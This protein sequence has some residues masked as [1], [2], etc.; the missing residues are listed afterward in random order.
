MK[1]CVGKC[2][3]VLVIHVCFIFYCCWNKWSQSSDHKFIISQFCSLEV[4]LGLTGFFALGLTRLKSR[5]CCPGL[6]SGGSRLE[7]GS[8]P[9]F[10]QMLAEFSFMLLQDWSPCTLP[11][12]LWVF[13][14]LEATLF[15]SS[16]PPSSL[17]LV[18]SF[19]CFKCLWPPLL[20]HL[21]SLQLEKVLCFLGLMWLGP[22]G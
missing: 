21:L 7:D 8:A 22:P 16:W 4:W 12:S 11:G 6:L 18:K 2:V 15:P 3:P 9:M 19:S 10:I 20:L 13:H 5:C 17:K 1:W 14:L